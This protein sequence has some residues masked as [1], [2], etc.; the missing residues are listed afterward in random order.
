[1][2]TKYGYNSGKPHKNKFVF[3]SPCPFKRI[4]L[5]LEIINIKLNW[6][7]GKF[8]KTLRSVF[9]SAFSTF[10]F[11]WHFDFLSS[12]ATLIALP[13]PKRKCLDFT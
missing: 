13:L 5:I 1:M 6:Y 12:F 9:T 3:Q 8:L 2:T 7:T 4:I 11:A 10:K